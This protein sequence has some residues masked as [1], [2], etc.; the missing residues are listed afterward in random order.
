MQQQCQEGENDSP[1]V[2]DEAEVF[3]EYCG[4]YH[5]E[6]KCPVFDEETEF[7]GDWEY[8]RL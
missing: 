5:E 8:G 7:F 1:V 6:G 2:E 3:C 4:D